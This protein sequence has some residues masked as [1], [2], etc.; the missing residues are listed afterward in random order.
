MTPMHY[1]RRDIVLLLKQPMQGVLPETNGENNNNNNKKPLNELKRLNW[2]FWENPVYTNIELHY[3]P[4][5]KK[6][7]RK[8]K[9]KDH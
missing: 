6:K 2:I 7:K 4:Q 9:K 1:S 8:K 3:L 5:K